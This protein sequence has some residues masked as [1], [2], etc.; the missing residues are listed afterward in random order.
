MTF[1]APGRL[2][3]LVGVAALVAVYVV[4]QRRRRHYAVRFTNLDLL[5]SVAPRRPGWRRHLPAAAIGLALGVLVVG[6]ARPAKDVRVPVE[7]ATIMLVVDS[8]FSMNAV[9]VE[10]SR[11]AAATDAGRKFISELPDGLKLGL[12]AFDRTP[13]V[14]AAPTTEHAAVERS[15]SQIVPGPGTAAGE[16]I[17][18]ALDAIAAADAA[19][20]VPGTPTPGPD[21]TPAPSPSP[22]SKHTAAIVLLSDGVTTVGRPVEEAAAAAAERRVP[23]MTIA[24]GTD[25]GV[26]TVNGRTI[27]VPA[28]PDTMAM[29]AEITGGTAF[30]AYSADE[31]RSVYEDIGSRVGFEVEKREIGM[32]F[33]AVATAMLILALIGALVWTGRVL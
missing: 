1:L 26:V 6:L 18:A 25:D 23:V 21:G 2:L 10:P 31:L 7:Q 32:T 33:V 30:E 22:G 12:V 14:L 13:R 5:A 29:V 11:M 9:D 24:F 19:V 20:G 17:Y 27:P 15:L 8:S 16:A 28:D 4:L 3:L